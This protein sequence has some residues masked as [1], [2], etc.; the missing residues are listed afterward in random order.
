MNDYSIRWMMDGDLSYVCVRAGVMTTVAQICIL[1]AFPLMCT[2]SCKTARFPFLVKTVYTFP[3]KAT[4][5]FFVREILY[6]HYLGRQ[7]SFLI[8]FEQCISTM[9][10]NNVYLSC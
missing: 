8:F 7:H 1:S 9:E 3:W 2:V 10:A 6:M 4:S 5:Y